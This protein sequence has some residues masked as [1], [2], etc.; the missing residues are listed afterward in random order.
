MN[1]VPYQDRDAAVE[2]VL[3]KSR[4]QRGR[5]EYVDV[6]DEAHPMNI[7][8][9]SPAQKTVFNFGS[10]T[11]TVE[12][13]RAFGKTDSLISP[14]MITTTQ[15]MPRGNGLFLGVSLK[16]LFSK[17]V[18][19]TIAAIER[20]TGL[21]EGRD[22]FRGHAP[23]KL[24]FLEPLVRP[25]VWDNVIHFKNGFIW[26]MISTSV[27]A[28]ANGL[29]TCA[30]VGD[31]GRFMPEATIKSE[32][33]PTLRGISSTHPGFDE[34]KNPYY[35][36]LLL[37]SDSPFSRRQEWLRKRADEQTM[38]VNR[39]IASMLADLNMV[40][41]N[42]GAEAAAEIASS[43]KFVRE[44]IR[45]RC[46]SNI[47]FSFS[48]LENISILG[49]DFIKSMKRELTPSMFNVAI[50]NKQNER[51]NDGYYSNL[52]IDEVHGYTNSDDSQMEA[53]TRAYLGRT[54][55]QVYTG[56][57]TVRVESESID[58]RQLSRAGDCTLDTDLDYKQPLRIAL[59]YGGIIN[60]MVVGQTPTERDTSVV[61][62][63]KSLVNTKP[64]RLEGLVD[65][66]NKYFEPK[67]ASS[68]DVIFYYDAT[69]KQGASYASER[70][71][72]TRFYRI[73][74]N[75][76][77]H[78]GWRVTEVP[79]GHP[80]SHNKKYEFLNGCLAGTQRPYIRINREN[81]Q[82]LIGSLENAGL[83]EG[84]N[85]FE[86]DKS[87][88]KY[89]VAADSIDPEAE[90]AVRTDLSDAFDTLIIGVR[91]YNGGRLIGVGM[92]MVG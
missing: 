50:L 80:M 57:R 55:T 53:A 88:E 9:M 45:L 14:R 24:S 65:L 40:E 92:P 4:I 5:A 42:Y 83:I 3:S 66:F 2:R 84:R 73:V 49:E 18:P 29:N 8:Y 75:R 16:Q 89:R 1:N 21:R 76:L 19:N 15:S 46:R 34:T 23:A 10:R 64:T 71:D 61:R 68:P 62:V 30:I 6:P 11:V 12:A 54:V 60:C 43:P 51:I 37:V 79:L 36:G 33:L 31:E 74:V 77:R 7:M 25:R 86:K 63:L 22:F 67:K 28:A 39:K 58:L 91:Y 85:G 20:M 69:A 35:K 17:T 32:I 13:G 78:H 44:I 47:Y 87:R 38:D 72:E 90:L 27:K 82:Y 48:T 52:N 41:K 70:Y 26:Y 81:N 56:G 59:D